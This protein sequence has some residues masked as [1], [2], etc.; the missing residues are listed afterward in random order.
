MTYT[1][2]QGD[3]ATSITVFILVGAS[4]SSVFQIPTSVATTWLGCCFLTLNE[5]AYSDPVGLHNL[6]LSL[7]A[8]SCE[9]LLMQLPW[10]NFFPMLLQPLNLSLGVALVVYM[11]PLKRIQTDHIMQCPNSL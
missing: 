8:E 7:L 3:F 6:C 1:H 2:V 11:N 10:L 4:H 9:L 5:S